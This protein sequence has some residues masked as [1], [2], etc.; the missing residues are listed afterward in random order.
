MKYAKEVIDLMGAHPGREFRMAQIVRHVSCAREL[1]ARQ[2][3]AVRQGVLRVLDSLEESGQVARE[4]EA[5]NSV[6]YVWRRTMRH[7]LSASMYATCDNT[8]SRVAS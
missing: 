6:F 1:S 5:T 8:G 7:D 3:N 2:R 4:T